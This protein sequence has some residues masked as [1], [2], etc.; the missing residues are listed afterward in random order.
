MIKNI[1]ASSKPAEKTFDD[2]VELMGDHNN[3]KSIPTVQRCLFKACFQKLGETVAKFITEL[4]RLTE[5]CKFQD[6]LDEMTQDRLVCG[7]N[8]ERWQKRLLV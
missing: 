2:I 4:K 5:Y 1:V 3:P 6:R 7:I 8:E